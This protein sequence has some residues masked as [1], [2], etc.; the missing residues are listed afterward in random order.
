MGVTIRIV[1]AMSMDDH[2][3]EK[4]KIPKVNT[5]KEKFDSGI[6]KTWEWREK[7]LLG[8]RKF[9]DDEKEAIFKALDD[10]LGRVPLEATTEWINTRNQVTCMLKN[11]KK[12]HEKTKS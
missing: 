12:T 3:W 6:T 2:E 8:L 4:I 1:R 9:L 5:A 10:D 11:G 7:Q